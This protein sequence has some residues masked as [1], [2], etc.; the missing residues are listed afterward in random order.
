MKKTRAFLLRA[1]LQSSLLMLMT[2]FAF[3]QT[4]T[5]SG[6]VSGAQ[7]NAGLAG[8]SVQVKGSRAGTTTDAAGDY[9]ITVPAGATLVFS[10]TGFETRQVKLG[11]ES[12]VNVT[13]PISNTSL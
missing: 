13:L 12:E 4:R 10:S 1:A 6:K 11:N 3:S 7:D 5:I 2:V 8:V 9:K